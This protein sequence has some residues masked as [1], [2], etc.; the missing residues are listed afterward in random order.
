MELK[1]HPGVKTTIA[2]YPSE[3]K[4]PILALRTLIIATA[5]K[6]EGIAYFQETLKWG[7]PSYLSPIGSTLR[8]AWK[9]SSPE[10]YGLYFHCQSKLVDS[11]REVFAKD[12][13]YQGNRA[14]IFNLGDTLPEKKLMPCISAALQYQRF[15]HLPL[16]G[17]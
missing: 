17:L 4:K 7:E 6:I 11:F 15:K 14:I 3:V 5:Q 2:S 9:P 8:L 1:S 16:L 10:H 13:L 12:F